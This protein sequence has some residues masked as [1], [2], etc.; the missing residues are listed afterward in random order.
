MG[1]EFFTGFEGCGSDADVLALFDAGLGVT[2]ASSGGY[3]NSKWIRIPNYDGYLRADVPAG[4]TKVAGVHV[5]NSNQGQ[6][7]SD[8]RNFMRFYGPDIRIFNYSS[9][10]LIYRGTTQ[11]AQASGVVISSALTH[12]EIKVFSDASAGT[13]DIKINGASVYSGTGLNTGGADITGVHIGSQD[14][15]N[16][17]YDNFHI[18]TDWMGELKSVLLSPTSDTATSDFTPSEGV[19]N[20]AMVDDTT[21]DGDT[22]Y[23]S[24]STTGHKDYYNY[25]DV[26]TGYTVKGVTVVTVARKID[27]GAKSVLVKATQDSTEYE[28][29]ETTL[30]TTYPDNVSTGSVFTLGS[31]P[32]TTAWTP[33]KLNAI[34]WGFENQ[35]P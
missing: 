24:S 35:V 5:Y 17:Y 16:C 8:A 13:V 6:N 29:G 2:Y 25:A 3:L 21:Q 26:D 11:I 14:Y 23:V 19:D 32:D 30:T 34:T 22:T 4:K 28:V 31:C 9:G 20:Y 12:V 27:V 1:L 10:I 18:A 7:N 15:N 33:A